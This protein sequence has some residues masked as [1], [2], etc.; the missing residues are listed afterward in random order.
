VI[1]PLHLITDDAILAR[2]DFPDLARAAMGI[3]GSKVALHIR[4]PGLEGREVFD[5]ALELREDAERLGAILLVNDRLDVVLALDLPGGHLG[6][7]SLLPGQARRILGP[8]R[9]LGLSVHNRVE[10]EG[11]R[12]GRIDFLVVGT[13][14]A[15][16][17]HPKAVPGGEGRLKEIGSAAKLPLVGIGGIRPDRVK[18]VMSAGAHG[19]AVR[20]GV[21]EAS[22]PAEAVRVYLQQLESHGGWDHPGG[23]MMPDS[24]RGFMQ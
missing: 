12:E 8:H 7:R 14:F 1:P 17:S 13:L 15:T 23:G 2:N 24:N 6:Q 4:G 19:V 5:L 16:P 9:I 11:A 20:G 18:E 22:D 3:G 21:W 10:A